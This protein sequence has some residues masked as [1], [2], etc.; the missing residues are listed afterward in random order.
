MN[1]ERRV[2]FCIEC[3][4][5]TEYAL[6]KKMMPKTIKGREY[7][8]SITTAICNECGAEFALDENEGR[9]PAC[10]S[11]DRVIVSGNEFIIKEIRIAE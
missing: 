11:S 9:C 7:I 4:R 5:E 3:R 8:F 6:K 2:G 10:D 1:S